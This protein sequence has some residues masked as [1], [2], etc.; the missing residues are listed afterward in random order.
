MRPLFIKIFPGLNLAMA[1]AN[2]FIGAGLIFGYGD[3]LLQ[4]DPARFK[5]II[6][7]FFI[8]GVLATAGT[9]S[10]FLDRNKQPLIRHC[11]ASSFNQTLALIFWLVLLTRLFPSVH[12]L[13]ALL[14]NWLLP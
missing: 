1:L 7:C 8:T 9:I 6:P 3:R 5:V 11:I 10:S 14:L 4:L 13:V 2:V 12:N